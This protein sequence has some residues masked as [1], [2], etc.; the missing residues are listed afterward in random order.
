MGICYHEHMKKI[1]HKVTHHYQPTNNTCGYAALATLLSYYGREYQPEELVRRVVQPKDSEGTSHG[2]VTAQL[3]DWC[4]TEGFQ[5]DM[6]ASDMYV[7]DLSWQDK[8]S[9]QIKKRLEEVKSKRKN[10][11][12]GEHWM[13]VYEEAY[14]AMLNHGANLTVVQFIT[15]ELL[16]KLLKDGP[17]Y[18]NICLNALSGRGRT[19]NPGLREDV[20]DDIKG[21]IATHSV[22]IYGNDEEGNFLV[23]DPWDGL[24]TSSPEYMILAIEAAQ[25]ECDNQI[26]VIEEKAV[27]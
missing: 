15:N 27:D 20:V 3:A 5:A 21:G 23:S 16:Y 24:T 26:F 9:E 1:V 17:V 10:A 7:L 19:T 14:I 6:Y 13:N 25:I 11:I 18:T 12:L 2:S 22:V 8:S 4:Q